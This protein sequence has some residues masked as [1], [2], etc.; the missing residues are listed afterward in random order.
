MAT[1][2]EYSSEDVKACLTVL[3]ELLTYLKPYEHHIVLIG[4]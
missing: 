1:I 3:L 2:T 4:G